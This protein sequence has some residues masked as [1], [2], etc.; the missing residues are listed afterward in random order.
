MST[1]SD[2]MRA[3]TLFTIAVSNVAGF[4]Y[5]RDAL[6][7]CGAM[8]MCLLLKIIV[9]DEAQTTKATSAA[10]EHAENDI[11]A[12]AAQFLLH[13][14]KRQAVKVRFRCG[15]RACS[16]R[17]LSSCQGTHQPPSTYGSFRL[18]GTLP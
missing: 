1:E 6:R 18:T 9:W 12:E 5:C 3:A 4:S 8:C 13:R 10:G 15:P 2:D 14:P 11:T 7:F 17:R 16:E